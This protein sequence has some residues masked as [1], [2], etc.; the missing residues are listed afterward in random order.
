MGYNLVIDQGNSTAKV[1]LFQGD[2]L[3]EH[4]RM[5]HLTPDALARLASSYSIDA[6]IYCSVATRGEEIIVSL[7]SFVKRVYEMTSMLPL[8]IKIGYATPST[9]GRDRIA[10]VAGAYAAHPGRNVLVVD[11]GTAVTYDRL[12]D[13]GEFAG[14]NI[15]PGLWVRAKALHDMTQRLPLVDVEN[16]EPASLWGRDTENAIVSGVV[17]GIVGETEFY[18]SRM[19]ENSIVMLTGGDARHLAGIMDFP[20][21]VDPDL[22]SKGLNSIL[23]YNE[24]IQ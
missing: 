6:A 13:D 17:Y 22:V 9:L 3:V 8:P 12:T 19:P 18:R 23:L 24:N 14:G 1:A 7:R 5:E 21:E 20:V 2:R 11:A 15:A 4:W 16:R 10:A